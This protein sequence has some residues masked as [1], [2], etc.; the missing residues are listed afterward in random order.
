MIDDEYHLRFSDSDGEDC[1]LTLAEIVVDI[2]GGDFT[3]I[4]VVQ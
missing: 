3:I 1:Y 4:S 2:D